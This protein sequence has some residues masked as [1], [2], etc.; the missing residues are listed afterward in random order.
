MA[1]TNH[2]EV[3]T[4]TQPCWLCGKDFCGDC[5]VEFQGHTMCGPCKS[6]AV[7]RLESGGVVGDEGS[8]L[9]PWENRAQLGM[10]PA[11]RE[12]GVKVMKGADSFFTRLDTRYQGWDCLW[13]PV[14]TQT[15]AALVSAIIQVAMGGAIGMAA[16]KGAFDPATLLSGGLGFIGVVLA[17]IQAI[18]GMFLF[19]GMVHLTL[20]VA[21]KARLPYQQTVRGICYASIPGILAVIPILGAIVGG[22]W[23]LVSTIIAIRAMHRTSTGMA[24]LAYFAIPLLFGCC[25]GALAIG[26]GGMAAVMSQK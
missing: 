26:L 16:N 9:A 7:T 22:I 3:L 11:F 17:P 23:A 24:L 10:V 25:F 5:I 4:G 20:V 13:I 1:C 12:T 8:E 19:G 6:E 14:I 21:K 18:L 2:P 15:I